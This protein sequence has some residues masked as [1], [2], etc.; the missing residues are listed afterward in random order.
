[1]HECK[2]LPVLCKVTVGWLGFG[3]GGEQSCHTSQVG[4]VSFGS[5]PCQPGP[6]SCLAFSTP[7]VPHRHMAAASPLHSWLLQ[8]LIAHKTPD[9]D[10][11]PF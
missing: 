2:S 8:L 9:S 11:I 1:M 10:I 6:A 3:A 7:R 4:G 5:C